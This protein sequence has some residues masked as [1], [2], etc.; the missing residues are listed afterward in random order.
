MLVEVGGLLFEV[1]DIEVAKNWWWAEASGAA[2]G[3]TER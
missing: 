1:R 3:F 2:K